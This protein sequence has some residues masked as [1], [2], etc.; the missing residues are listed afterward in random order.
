MSRSDHVY[1]QD[2]LE[3]IEIIFAYVDNKTDFEF[4]RDLMLQDAVIRR[5]E[6]IGVAAS[7][8]SEQTKNQEPNCIMEAYES[9]A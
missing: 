8:I 9:N 4:S 3:S 2:I 7:K 6:V 1:I 5:F